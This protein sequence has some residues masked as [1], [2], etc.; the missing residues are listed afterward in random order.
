MFN[1]TYDYVDGTLGGVR[2]GIIGV[3][4]CNYDDKIN[5]WK[6]SSGSDYFSVDI[7]KQNIVEIQH[8][9][10]EKQK[11]KS[12]KLV[13][14]AVGAAVLGG[15]MFTPLGPAIAGAKLMSLGFAASKFA[16]GFAVGGAVQGAS[17][18]VIMDIA[19]K[20]TK[21]NIFMISYLDENDPENLKVI[22][23]EHGKM[24]LK[25]AM[26]LFNELEEQDKTIKKSYFVERFIKKLNGEEVTDTEAD[27]LMK[28]S[29]AH[30]IFKI[31]GNGVTAIA[32]STTVRNVV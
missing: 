1:W 6:N 22:V 30:V 10:I 25:D 19:N 7:P 20:A 5:V 18:G 3:E 24:F 4:V 13:Y 27:F 17:I 16:V 12:N 2:H 29:P 21:E 23:L 9:V 11:E 28:V 26:Q 31:D 14:S 32:L 15:L 8:Y